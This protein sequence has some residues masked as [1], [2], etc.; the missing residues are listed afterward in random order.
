M[1]DAVAAGSTRNIDLSL[2]AAFSFTLDAQLKA[3][4]VAVL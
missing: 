3:R 4:L 2:D 1:G